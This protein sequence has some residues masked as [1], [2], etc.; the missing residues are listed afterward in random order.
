MHSTSIPALEIAQRT[1]PG[2]DPDKQ[3]NEDACGHRTTRFGELLAVCDGMGGHVGGKEASTRALAAIFETFDAAAEGS[4]GRDVLRRAVEVANERVWALASPGADLARPGSTAVAILVHAGGV[5]VAHVGDSRCYWVH[6]GQVTQVTKD[7]SLVQGLVDAGVLAQADAKNHPSANRITRALG[8]RATVEV[9]VA[10]TPL[11]LVAGD[12]FLLC[13]DGLSDLVEPEDIVSIAGG[14][15]PA[16]AAGRLVDLANARGGH[17]NIT[18]VLV[19][20]REGAAVQPGVAPTVAQ[21]YVPAAQTYVPAAQTYVPAATAASEPNPPPGRTTPPLPVGRAPKGRLVLAAGLALA[22]LGLAT[23]AV[24]LWLGLAR[25]HSGHH[26]GPISSAGHLE[27]SGAVPNAPPSAV[28]GDV[29]S[30]P[31]TPGEVPAATPSDLP[32]LRRRSPQ[33]Q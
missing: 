15:P 16:Q 7:H 22:A 28:P 23:A 24:V 27:P 4:A 32:R 12:V 21:T 1:D 14:Q 29:S 2:R 20:V 25:P 17:D 30:A 11:P 8:T 9:E 31:P 18:A 33:V 3:V 10:P 26:R 13:S 6:A 5:E 19:R